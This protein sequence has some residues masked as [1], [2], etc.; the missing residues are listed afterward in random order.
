M[1]KLLPALL[2]ALSLLCAPSSRADAAQPVSTSCSYATTEDCYGFTMITETCTTTY[3][4]GTASSSSRT[5]ADPTQCLWC[6][7]FYVPCPQS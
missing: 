7:I 3:S 2:L 5:Y 1:R 4:N 6:Y